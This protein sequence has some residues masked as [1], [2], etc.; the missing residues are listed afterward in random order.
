M[1]VWAGVSCHPCRGR[2][3]SLEVRAFSSAVLHGIAFCLPHLAA[4][5]AWGGVWREPAQLDGFGG[6]LCENLA[7]RAVRHSLAKAEPAV[8]VD[9]VVRLS[10]CL[11]SATMGPKS[12]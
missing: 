7:I 8:A 2:C 5:L 10:G 3:W 12:I 4:F 1:V 6:P 11:S 9:A